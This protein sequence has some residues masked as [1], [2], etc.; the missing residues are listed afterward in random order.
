VSADPFDLI[1][2]WFEAFNSADLDALMALYHD[3][4]SI[5]A[6]GELV[7]GRDA[8]ERELHDLLRRSANRTVRMIARVETGAMHAEWRGHERS[9]ENGDLS[10]SAGYDD[11]GVELGRIRSQRTVLHPLTFQVEDETVPVTGVRPYPEYGRFDYYQSTANVQYKALYVKVEK[12]YRDRSQFLVSYTL[13]K[14]DDSLPLYRTFDPYNLSVDWGPSNNDRRHN[15]VVS[16]SFLLPA[17]V[18][19]GA[20]YQYRSELPWNAVAGRD[21]N[22]DGFSSTTGITGG[23]DLVPGTTRNSGS[24]DLNLAAVNSYRE[25]NGLPPV[26]ESD[27]DSS[28]LSSL[29]VR[30]SKRFALRGEA[31]FEVMAQIFNL[32]NTDNLRGIYSAGGRVSNALSTNF[33]AIFDA[34]PKLQ[35][36]I[37]VKVLF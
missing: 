7:R 1:R 2:K 22:G 29:D 12:R 21:L 4:A 34:R 18:S 5:D 35:A 36:E 13:A 17:D 15:L 25:L 14:S 23:A 11:F 8:V 37:A 6:G 26:N 9:R 20:V 28:R 27:I 30:V 10:T 24:R 19:I 33:G 32:L 3:D 16:G 31:R